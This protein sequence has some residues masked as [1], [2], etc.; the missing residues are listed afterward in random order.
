MTIGNVISEG[1][2]KKIYATDDP[3]LAV[4][5]YKDETIAYYGL[6]RRRII[7][8]GELNNKISAHL[9]KLLEK[10][11]IPTHFVKV[12]DGRQAL[13][14]RG[15]MIPITVTYRNIVAGSLIERI[16]YPLGTK[17][18][19]PIVECNLKNNQL[20]NPLIN[21][22]HIKAMGLARKEE[23][24]YIYNTVKKVNEILSNYLKEVEIELI[25]FK[26]EFGRFKGELL[27][28]DELSPDTCRF[29]DA[30]T[31]EP[32]DI[33]LFRKDLGDVTQGYKEVLHRL[34]GS[35]E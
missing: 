16:G 18:K 10:E 8:K 17:L 24:E 30:K 35:E 15:E 2:G 4:V 25:D 29:W 12:L 31:R 33:D 1:K 14:K 23:M 34:M 6:K 21:D 5:Y 7:G 20:S 22:S 27:L 9:F 32:L 19:S 13:V 28:A 26:M 11:G 3:Q